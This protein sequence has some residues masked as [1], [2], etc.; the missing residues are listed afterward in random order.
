MKFKVAV[1]SLLAAILAV[2]LFTS[3]TLIDKANRQLKL[4]KLNTE[5]TIQQ[6]EFDFHV[7]TYGK[8]ELTQAAKMAEVWRTQVEKICGTN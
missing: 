6:H 8:D 2:C 5:I 3:Y 7:I 1:I 4:E